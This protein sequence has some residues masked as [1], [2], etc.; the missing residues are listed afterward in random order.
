MVFSPGVDT[1]VLG[2]DED[3]ERCGTRAGLGRSRSHRDRGPPALSGAHTPERVPRMRNRILKET[4]S[5]RIRFAD[6][7]RRMTASRWSA[8]SSWAAFSTRTT[9]WPPSQH[10]RFS[11]DENTGARIASGAL[12]RA[13]RNSDRHSA[14][15]RRGRVTPVSSLSSHRR[16]GPHRFLAAPMGYRTTRALGAT[17]TL[18]E[19]CWRSVRPG[20]GLGASAWRRPGYSTSSLP[21]RLMTSR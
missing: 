13:V 21:A 16:A 19:G 9:E 8:T 20:A 15:W 14:P 10:W 3:A 1:P 4:V 11:H 17:L 18:D 12:G 6:E 2:G 7:E 5:A